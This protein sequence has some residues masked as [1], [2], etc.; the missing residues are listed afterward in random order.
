[1]H[2]EEVLQDAVTKFSRR[3]QE[4]E[5]KVHAA[6]KEITQ[7]SLAELDKYWEAAKKSEKARR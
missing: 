1:M 3:F 6:G 7:C 5:R 2:A 4:V